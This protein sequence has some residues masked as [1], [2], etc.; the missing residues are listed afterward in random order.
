MIS[1]AWWPLLPDLRGDQ[2]LTSPRWHPHVRR[3][4]IFSS[5]LPSTFPPFERDPTFY[6]IPNVASTLMGGPWVEL[7]KPIPSGT[8]GETYLLGPLIHRSIIVFR[9][10]LY[11]MAIY[12]KLPQIQIHLGGYGSNLGIPKWMAF[13]FLIWSNLH[14]WG[15]SSPLFSLRHWHSNGFV[16]LVWHL[17]KDSVCQARGEVK[18]AKI[19][20]LVQRSCQETSYRDLL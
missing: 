17:I 9:T 18:H 1:V 12:E 7:L 15:S 3:I 6:W 4:F 11:L 8:V 19:L 13:M 14:S 10:F 16:F 2:I 5:D 20:D